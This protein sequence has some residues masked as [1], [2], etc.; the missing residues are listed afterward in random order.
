LE[1]GDTAWKTELAKLIKKYKSEKEKKTK[2]TKIFLPKRRPIQAPT[3]VWGSVSFPVRK[4][5]RGDTYTHHG[6]H[7]EFFPRRGLLAVDTRELLNGRHCV[8][9]C[10]C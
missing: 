1:H 9:G 4:A 7:L 8:I 3:V 6:T 5:H 2:K 10:C